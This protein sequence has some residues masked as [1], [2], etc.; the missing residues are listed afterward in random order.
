MQQY[1]CGRF[2]HTSS[3]TIECDIAVTAALLHDIGKAQTFSD[4]LSRTA[5]GS[6]AV[7]DALTLEICAKP[8]A[9]LSE[10]HPHIANQL[11]HAWTCASPNAR[12]GFTPET[13]VAKQLQIADR[14]NSTEISR[15]HTNKVRT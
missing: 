10:V 14:R 4:N 3:G 13:R 5:I 12:Y 2:N 15:P 8:L 6:L 9:K 1:C 11:R 7:H